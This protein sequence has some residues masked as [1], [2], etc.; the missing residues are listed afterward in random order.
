MR[1]QIVRSSVRRR[2]LAALPL[3]A[4][5]LGACES[6]TLG[7]AAFESIPC[8]LP[9]STYSSIYAQPF[10]P[11]AVRSALLHA[12][13]PMTSALGSGAAVDHVRTGLL[14]LAETLGNR[15]P[16][17]CRQLTVV[18]EALTAVPTAPGMLADR[19]GIRLIIALAAGALPQSV[20]V[21]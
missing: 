21:R 14:E 3:V 2:G 13:G 19:D 16:V 20:R 10:Q 9:F 7:P 15:A 11:E 6:S 8:E 5:A 12:A 1:K 17:E 4:L 18:S